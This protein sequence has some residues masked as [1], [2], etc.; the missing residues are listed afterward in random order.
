MTFRNDALAIATIFM[1]VASGPAVM[2]EPLPQP[3]TVAEK[4]QLY[5]LALAAA[6]FCPAGVITDKAKAFAAEVQGADAAVFQAEADKIVAAWRLGTKCSELE[7]DQNQ[8][9]MCRTAHLRNCRA[10]WIQLGPD[11]NVRPGFIDSDYSKV[12]TKK[13]E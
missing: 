9:A 2:A 7:L 1:A 13:D 5:G 12:D 6:E 4:G 3:Q 8:L 10:A 11:G